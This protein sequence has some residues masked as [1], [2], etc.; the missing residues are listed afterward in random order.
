[1]SAR[2]SP[3]IDELSTHSA[4]DQYPSAPQNTSIPS[5]NQSQEQPSPPYPIETTPA[6]TPRPQAAEQTVTRG[7]PTAAELTGTLEYAAKRFRVVFG[8]QTQ[9]RSVDQGVEYAR[10]GKVRGVVVVGER[11]RE[12][13]QCVELKVGPSPPV[14]YV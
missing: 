7:P 5:E 3:D 8:A 9:G 1:M 10:G 4:E 6:Y 2:S 13:V 14:Y 11:Y 12:K